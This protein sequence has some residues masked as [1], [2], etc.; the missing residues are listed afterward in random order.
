MPSR[1]RC[2]RLA[3]LAAAL[4]IAAPFA[5]PRAAAQEPPVS[6]ADRIVT[7][8]TAKIAQAKTAGELI[9]L[10]NYYQEEMKSS[11]T[12]QA[13]MCLLGILYPKNSPESMVLLRQAA[14]HDDVFVAGRLAYGEAVKA[15][16]PSEALIAL[17]EAW[18]LRPADPEAARA[19]GILELERGNQDAA[20]DAAGFLL[21]S[22][23]TPERQAAGHYLMGR[24]KL[25]IHDWQAAYDL[26]AKA[27][28]EAPNDPE[29]VGWWARLA[30][31]RG[32]IDQAAK[33]ISQH[34]KDPFAQAQLENAMAEALTT[35]AWRELTPSG[36]PWPA[37]AL[38]WRN[39][40]AQ[41][42]D[43]ARSAVPYGMVWDAER[44]AGWVDT[45]KGRYASAWRRF[46][47]RVPAKLSLES[48]GPTP[49]RFKALGEAVQ[50][51]NQKANL[52]RLRRLRDAMSA[53][54]WTAEALEK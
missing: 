27:A 1:T 41:G 11:D 6:T 52:E 32:A 21:Q 26:M 37:Q 39:S 10:R 48:R 13:Y 14:R 16:V 40:L 49:E 31:S 24:L 35:T 36:D 5:R 54:G 28:E 34:S 30:V 43:Q 46:L 3:S 51:A 22:P 25:E 17:R 9:Q 47:Q 33:K 50:A 38:E 42:Y 4:L 7:E 12:P 29:I 2:R 8:E 44:L 19:Y 15:S 23:A 20:A 53:A 45:V 18:R